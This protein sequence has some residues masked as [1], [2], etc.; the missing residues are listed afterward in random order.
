MVMHGFD[1][2]E[3]DSTRYSLVCNFDSEKHFLINKKLEI[4]E[5]N[6]KR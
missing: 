6:K 4:I 2:H 1:K 3:N 5:K